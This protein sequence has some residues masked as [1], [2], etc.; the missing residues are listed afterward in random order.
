[1]FDDA[2]GRLRL[3]VSSNH[4]GILSTSLD[5]SGEKPII[6]QGIHQTDQRLRHLEWRGVSG[7]HRRTP[8]VAP[9]FAVERSKES[10]CIRGV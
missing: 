5:I 9:L 2:V 4:L 6:G 3:V 7:N 8:V 1:V 10:P